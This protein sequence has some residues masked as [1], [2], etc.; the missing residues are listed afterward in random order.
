MSKNSKA[1]S[2]LAT[3]AN[4]E[5]DIRKLISEGKSKA[6]LDQ[7]KE[8]HKALHTPASEALL[9]DSYI[10]RVHSML[11]QKMAT[12]ARSLMDLVRERFPEAKEKLNDL[13]QTV[14]ARTGDLEELIAPLNDAQ[15]DPAKRATIEQVIQTQ[16][17]DLAALAGCTAL[18]AEH[19]LR[20]AAAALHQAFQAVTSGPVTDEQIE[21]PE[22]SYRSPLASWK[23]LI[24]AIASYYRENDEE[25]LEYLAAIKPESVPS[26]LTPAI[27]KMLGKKLD[28]PLKL[29]ETN[30]VTVTASSLSTL[31]RA[32]ESVEREYDHGSQPAP[33][34][35]A[36]RSAVRECQASAPDRLAV[37]K[38]ILSARARAN[39]FEEERVNAALDGAAREDAEYFRMV[40]RT[41]ESFHDADDVI[42]ACEVWNEF[43]MSAVSENL[44]PESGVEVVTLYL[45]M[46]DLLAKVPAQQLLIAQR[47][48]AMS[49][50]SSAAE[51][52]YFLD[53]EQLFSR[54]CT[55]DPQA[56][57]F[58]QWMRWASQQSAKKGENVARQWNGIRPGDLEPLLYLMKEA[59]KR[60]ALPKALSHLDQAERID[61]LHPE[62]RAAR[63]HLLANA[64]VRH[65][66]QNKTHL[67]LEKLA[68]IEALPQAQQGY[69]PGFVFA[70]RHLIALAAGSQ[71]A[72]A[73]ALAG[74]EKALGGI[75]AAKVLVF[76][77]ASISKSMPWIRLPDPNEFSA[78]ERAS[79]PSSLVAAFAV[80]Q[81]IG[82]SKT[83]YPVAYFDEIEKQFPLVSET[84]DV[85]QLR[86]LGQLS[87]NVERPK[88]SWA[89]SQ[90]GLS[91]GGPTEAFFL[92]LRARIA[93][94]SRDGRY[95]ALA[96]AAV[97]LGRA[98]G[99]P[100][101]VD[102]AFEIMRNPYGRDSVKLTLEQSREVVKR[103]LASPAF[104][105]SDSVGP[106]YKDLLPDQ[107]C[108]CWE[109]RR[110]RGEI[111]YDSDFNDIDDDDGFDYEGVDPDEEEAE[112]IEQFK[113]NV[114]RDMPPEIVD[115]FC[116]VLK[117]GLR[118]G[119]TPAQVMS[120]IFAGIGGPPPRSTRGGAKK[121]KK[122]GG[123]RR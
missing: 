76:G 89:V 67:A 72:A 87:L 47:Q 11:D 91:R 57:A 58:S 83:S 64:A 70:M 100:K 1:S 18:P 56:D 107:R 119:K 115:A 90:A 120:E 118:S 12:E 112:L 113:D 50:H 108:D 33:L 53:P 52:H 49:R 39:G 86:Q 43:L 6:A 95:V 117:D 102:K 14:S 8:F 75:V 36:I 5:S 79:F 111:P 74:A 109:C 9:L 17:T 121:A 80:T 26:R 38:Q 46:A 23:A 84:L 3:G 94:Q 19:S 106:D 24:R 30:L 45:H 51:K 62:V 42:E 65:L 48:T 92:W 99:D 31:R 69:R 15:L 41:L 32:L 73:D 71:S 110:E 101:I 93:P 88:L 7:A 35:K 63:L 104:P 10:A 28:V 22:V 16:V 37:L 116:Q 27:R 105:R 96:A 82:I 123:K 34:L 78:E 40:A 103:E 60:N 21:L 122:K 55:I 20:Q 13:V 97:E 61:P 68:A 66:Q 85:E 59:E 29:A 114:P 44:F 81:D 25:C 98:H 77:L 54:A 2:P 4:N